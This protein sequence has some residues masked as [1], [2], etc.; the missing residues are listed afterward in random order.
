MKTY[1][2]LLAVGESDK[3]RMDFVR[4]CITAH[5]ASELFATAKL[6]ND[7]MSGRNTTIL[8]LQKT[9]VTKTGQI[10]E[11]KWSPNHKT[12]SNF[13]NRFVTQETQYLLGNGV[14][15]QN[16][17]TPK[18]LG[19]DFDIR[20]QEAAKAA[21]AGAV[22]FGFYNRDHVEIFS[23]AGTPN[24]PCYF[25]PLYDENN[26]ALRAGI[27]FWRLDTSKPLRATLYEQEGVT[28]YIWNKR[29]VDGKVAED[30]YIMQA[31]TPY[32]LN[33]SE[34]EADG[35]ELYSGENYPALP[36][37]PLF[38]NPLH[39]SE[40]VGLREKIDAYDLLQNG[41]VNDLD[42]A[43][44]YWILKNANGADN[45]ELAEFLDQLKSMKAANVGD[46]TDIT[47]VTVDIP[48]AAREVI[49]SRLERQLYKDYKALDTDA[50]AGGAATATQI[51]A[52]YEPME[53][54]S[55]EFEG[56]VLDF[57]YG[58]LKVA[59]I[60]GEKPS[61]TRTRIVNTGEEVQMVLS[62]ASFLGEDYTIRKVLT[63]LGDGDKADK[64]IEQRAADQIE[65]M[66]LAMAAM[67]G[68]MSGYST[69]PNGYVNQTAG[70]ADSAGV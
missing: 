20:L 14:T 25:C 43:Q 22:S 64:I 31:R 58:I 54:K 47:P 7:Y 66:R 39:Q 32:K 69:Q 1:N 27:R 52:A 11:D 40:L 6:G 34:T 53:I 44:I 60:E 26:G 4:E 38:G 19:Q 21:L 15:W 10:V 33:L 46:L 18:K 9:L 29:E 68:D 48:Y 51:K 13:F 36:I 41:E 37:V 61:F 49:L 3:A 67:G 62:A 55:S 17:S 30:G 42:T 65:Q 70:A 2:D 8:N 12:A 57:I 63:L 23:L 16:E 45:E 59:G 24:D 50:I 28:E 56:C 5:K 35:A